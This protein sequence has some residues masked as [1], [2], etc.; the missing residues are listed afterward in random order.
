MLTVT[1]PAASDRLLE[2]HGPL[3]DEENFYS[4]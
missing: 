3:P 4:A 1:K 2:W